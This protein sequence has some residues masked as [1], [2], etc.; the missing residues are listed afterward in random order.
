MKIT[1][2]ILKSFGW[3]CISGL[4]LSITPS[5]KYSMTLLVLSISGLSALV[6][7]LFGFNYMTF[8]GF[9]ALMLLE[10]ITGIYAS[11]KVRKEP[12]QSAKM[13]RFSIKV[14]I[15]M[16]LLFITYQFQK[17]FKIDNTLVSTLF[18]WVWNFLFAWFALEY[19]I[20]VL[21]NYAS[22]K[23]KDASAMIKSI[24]DKFNSIF[25]ITPIFI[26]LFVSCSVSSCNRKTTHTIDKSTHV[27]KDSV[28]M[29]ERLY[30]DTIRVK[31]DSITQYIQLNCDSLGRVVPT[32]AQ[33]K[34]IRASSHMKIDSTGM[35]RID[36]NCDAWEQLVYK[37]QREQITQKAIYDAQIKQSH[38]TKEIIKNSEFAKFCIGF[39][40]V[41]WAIF[42]GWLIYKIV[43]IYIKSQIKLPF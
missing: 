3:D 37:M 4:L 39:S 5:Y 9:I 34:S 14:F 23:G 35:M 29:V 16:T 18:N 30:I 12:L 36:C 28:W 6:E 43:R 19:L 17:G 2:S 26:L 15:I 11:V 32:Q 31:G 27:E 33:A 21:E 42:I 20:S 25:G 40:I 41:I 1:N 8:V 24:K 22:I 13:S 38:T 7:N 10:V